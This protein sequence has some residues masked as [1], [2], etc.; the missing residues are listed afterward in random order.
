MPDAP[1]F[2]A[3]VDR[4][5]A[6]FLTWPADEPSTARA[7]PDLDPTPGPACLTS[8]GDHDG[9][10][11]VEAEPS[12]PVRRD[13][14]GDWSWQRGDGARAGVLGV[15]RDSRASNRARGALA[16]IHE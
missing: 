7:W 4:R 13:R 1:D 11:L 6:V 9:S 14:S 16:T 3:G 10:V 8:T 5:V 2:A 12:G 15:A